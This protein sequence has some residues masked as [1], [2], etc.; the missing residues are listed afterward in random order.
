MLLFSN[1]FFVGT[2][3]A[4]TRLRQFSGE[5]PDLSHPGLKLAWEM[6]ETLEIYLTGCQVGI[7]FSSILL[8]IVAEPAVTGIFRGLFE[9]MSVGTYSAHAVSISLSVVLINM[10]HTVWGEQTPT[11]LGIERAKQVA[12]YCATPLYY[13]TNLTYPFIWFGDKVTKATLGLFGIRISRSWLE[14]QEKPSKGDI[15]TEIG[16]ILKTGGMS[17]DRRDEVIKAVEIEEIPSRK[18]MV[19]REDIVTLSTEKS[20]NENLETIGSHMHARYPLVGQSLDDFK[21]ILYTPQIMANVKALMNGKRELDD[22]DWPRMVVPDELP[23]SELIDRFQERHHE[24]ALVQSG[25]HITGL[26][27]LT[28][29]I[30]T[31]IGAAEDPLDLIGRH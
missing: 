17:S 16:R 24:L 9:G 3:F 8:G 12:R 20:F 5:D 22:F 1:A 10:A 27:T 14:E 4:L 25:R 11:Y 13:W 23:V 21:G 2:E 29:A 31:I 18:I 6:T 30:E 19:P 26:V 15:R 28:D 7:T